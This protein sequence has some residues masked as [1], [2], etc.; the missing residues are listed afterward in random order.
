MPLERSAPGSKPKGKKHN[1]T[2][3]VA[4]RK[5][6]FDGFDYYPTPPWA[7]QAF[8]TSFLCPRHDT[9]AMS[10]WEPAVG[11][12]DMLEPLSKAFSKV[13]ASD[14]TDRGVG[15]VHDFLKP[16]PREAKN[17][18]W[19]IT[20]P[21]FD[22]SVLIPFILKALST[23][24][25]GVALLLRIQ[26]LETKD[27]FLYLFENNP[28]T[29]VV[30]H[31][32]RVAMKKNGL[33]EAGNNA[34]CFAWFVWDKTVKN[35]QTTVDW[36]P[37]GSFKAFDPAKTLSKRSSKKIKRGIS[38]K[39]GKVTR[40]WTEEALIPHVVSLLRGNPGLPMS[41]A[42]LDK[43]LRL[44][45][46]PSGLDVEKTIGATFDRFRRTLSNI[47]S[48]EPKTKVLRAFRINVTVDAKSKRVKLI[49]SFS[50]SLEPVG[51]AKT[52]KIPAGENGLVFLEG[53]RKT[54]IFERDEVQRSSAVVAAA[55]KMRTNPDGTIHC[56]ACGQDDRVMCIHM[57]HVKPV[58]S[59]KPGEFVTKVA[60]LLPLCPSCHASAHHGPNGLV[61]PRTLKQLLADQNVKARSNGLRL[62][63]L[64]SKFFADAIA[65][66]VPKEQKRKESRH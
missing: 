17:V 22:R 43:H 13:I 60:D 9:W 57:H 61:K 20:N 16:P 7:T 5:N 46:N 41:T 51:E 54:V 28:P 66:K 64:R 62:G 45:L 1:H 34:A 56:L 19:V 36:V 49:A 21:P 11:E 53:Q 39:S 25:V 38:A 24:K 3:S 26:A 44:K 52:S 23:A 2:L 40:Q 8:L 50:S 6:S 14:L 10:C 42:D 59:R 48:H 15:F 47:V 58:A 65:G 18:D 32:D 31:S 4:S 12:G 35:K 55:I 37:P 33:S 30:V 27:R 63:G 29:H